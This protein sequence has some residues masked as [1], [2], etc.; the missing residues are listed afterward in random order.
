[1]CARGCGPFHSGRFRLLVNRM[2]LVG[3]CVCVLLLRTSYNEPRAGFSCIKEKKKRATSS[4]MRQHTRGDQLL[5]LLLSI[6][7]SNIHPLFLSLSPSCRMFQAKKEKGPPSLGRCVWFTHRDW[8]MPAS[9]SVYSSFSFPSDTLWPSSSSSLLM[10][11]MIIIISLCVC[12]CWGPLWSPQ[13]VSFFFFS[14]I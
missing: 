8:N 7:T 6:Y 13:L 3:V 12:V 14:V 5:L 1:M 11:M 2:L 10:M 9:Y 4:F